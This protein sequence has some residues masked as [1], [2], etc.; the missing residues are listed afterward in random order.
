MNTHWQNLWQAKWGILFIAGFALV[1]IFAATRERK[2][3]LADCEANGGRLV[4]PR[5]D[6]RQADPGR[7]KSH[8]SLICKYDTKA[9]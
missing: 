2:S 8:P 5:L 9:E 7:F 1:I 4:I 3:P 6:E